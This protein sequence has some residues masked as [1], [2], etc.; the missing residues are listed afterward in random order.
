MDQLSIIQRAAQ[1]YFGKRMLFGLESTIQKWV[2]K[3]K[4]PLKVD[5][6]ELTPWLAI[7]KLKSIHNGVKVNIRV[8]LS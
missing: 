7:V 1:I 3:K 6:A 2:D 8:R 4:L 5:G